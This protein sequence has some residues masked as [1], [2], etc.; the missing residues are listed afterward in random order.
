MQPASFDS[1]AR[2]YDAHFT[3][4]SIGFMQR[5]QVYRSLLPLLGK[6][7]NLLELNCGTGYD[8]QQLI[9]HVKSVFATDI[10]P[11][12]IARC[13]SK[14]VPQKPGLHFAV[15]SVQQIREELRATDFIFS[16][17]GGLNCL[18]P[19]E[20]NAFAQNCDEYTAAGTELF[21][22]FLG[23]KCVWEK[24]YY[25]LKFDPAKA[26]RRRK[27]TGVA[28]TINENAFS[29]WYYSP[30]EIEQMF[31][32]GFKVQST[33]PVGLFVPPSYLNT[34]FSNKKIL[35][36]LLGALDQ[37]FCKFKML[38]NYGDHFYI[39]FKRTN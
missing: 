17:F 31:G 36:R 11:E 22:V 26:F 27:R 33:G 9:A 24:L 8:A 32:G 18:S 29:T 14:T 3:Y 6:N 5:Q 19:A 25:L 2:H 21:F 1:Y 15:K 12:M 13:I 10:S 20:L 23:R 4:S 34:F 38:A 28:T 30:C 16:N 35:L 39:H 7:K 37:F